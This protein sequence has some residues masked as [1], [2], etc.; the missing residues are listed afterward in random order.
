[1]YGDWHVKQYHSQFYAAVVRLLRI[2]FN[3]DDEYEEMIRA[4]SLCLFFRITVYV[5]GAHLAVC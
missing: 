2:S 1:M 3:L 5:K 4:I